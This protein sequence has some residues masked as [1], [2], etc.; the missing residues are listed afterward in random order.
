MEWVEGSIPT[1]KGDIFIRYS[2]ESN[3]MRMECI[4]PKGV[5]AEVQIALDKNKEYSVSG[6]NSSTTGFNITGRTDTCFSL[7]RE[8]KHELKLDEIIK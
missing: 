5:E 8:G 3:S 7:D 1:V 2:Q 4:L 6:P